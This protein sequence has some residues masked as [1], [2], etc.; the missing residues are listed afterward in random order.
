MPCRVGARHWTIGSEEALGS[1]ADAA[2][3]RSTHARHSGALGVGMEDR[4]LNAGTTL[5]THS[6]IGARYGCARN[7]SMMIAAQPIATG[8]T[9]AM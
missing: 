2:A 4:E 3:T 8:R 5:P 1:T 7:D 9:V 6:V